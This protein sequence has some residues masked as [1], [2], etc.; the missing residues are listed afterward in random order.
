MKRI[1]YSIVVI[2]FYAVT[3]LQAQDTKKTEYKVAAIGFY[4]V[5]NLYDTLDQEGVE[6]SEFLPGGKKNY[7]SAVYHDKLDHLADVISQLGKEVT[8]DGLAIMGM[9]EIEN[10]G[11][12]SDLIHRPKLID[13]NYQ[14]LHYDSPD[15][16]G[17]DVA[18]IYQPKFF[19]PI[20]SAPVRV[21]QVDE[22][23]KYRP[24]R[25]ILYVK[26][27]LDGDT[28]HL[29]VNHW[30]S[31]RGGEAASQQYRNGVAAMCKGIADSLMKVN[32]ESKI[33]IMGDLNDDPISPSCAQIIG[34]KADKKDV[35][36]GQFYNPMYKFY[37]AG[38][39]T[40]AYNDAWN[41]FDQIM[42]SYGTLN[43]KNGGYHY[44][45]TRIFNEPFLTQTSGAYKGYPHRTFVGDRY[46]AGY[47]DHFPVYL[48]FVKPK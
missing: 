33:F 40:L 21:N 41:L 46:D 45:K 15:V 11:V 20:Y 14:I 18:M 28:I 1:L 6:D 38:I 44:L 2:C 5:E 24:T 29:M 34:A 32:P 9:A 4:N 25:D 7:T 12:I 10:E 42:I 47:S 35:F 17:V 48:L 19:T 27:L 8:K 39:G 36:A 43:E 23:G 26:G 3:F 30:P 37:K 16:R 22:K 13:K 31:R